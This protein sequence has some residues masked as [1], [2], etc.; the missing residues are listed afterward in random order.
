[1]L[2]ILSGMRAAQPSND[3]CSLVPP[4]PKV[5]GGATNQ[6]FPDWDNPQGRVEVALSSLT[7]T[8]KVFIQLGQSLATNCID[9]TYAV[10]NPTKVLNLS[11]TN[12]AIYQGKDPWMGCTGYH[13]NLPGNPWPTGHWV[14]QLGDTIY[15]NKAFN[16][17]WATIGVGGSNILDWQVGGGNNSRLAVTKRRLD[18]LGL[19]PNGVLFNQGTSN[20]G[21]LQ[22]AYYAALMSMIGTI[23]GLWPT[24]P[25]FIAQ[26]SRIGTGATS[27]EVRAAQAQA[28][29]AGNYVYAGPDTDSLDATYRQSDSLHWNASTGRAAVAG[30][31]YSSLN[32]I[33]I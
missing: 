24:V 22:A 30:L 4:Y 9:G 29:D 7:G 11:I 8:T 10:S 1:M 18:R 16:T 13:P 33:V 19:T 28:W 27:S 6:T 23:R 15:S 2:D 20:Y 31:W 32:G 3:P 12:G 17:I 14:G 21:T 5:T 26:E 25:I